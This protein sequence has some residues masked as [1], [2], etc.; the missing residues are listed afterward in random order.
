MLGMVARYAWAIIYVYERGFFSEDPRW[1]CDRISYKLVWVISSGFSDWLASVY[2]Y[3]PNGGKS[4]TINADPPDSISK[5]K[6]SNHAKERQ[7]S[8]QCTR[9]RTC[10]QDLEW[11]AFG[12]R[13]NRLLLRYADCL[14]GQRQPGGRDPREASD[15]DHDAARQRIQAAGWISYDSPGQVTKLSD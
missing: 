14:V 1:L 13:G 5:E 15:Q 4:H 6:E 2:S 12:A 9:E 11:I 10:I 3:S 8:L 7:A